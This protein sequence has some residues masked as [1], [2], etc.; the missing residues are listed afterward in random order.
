[1]LTQFINCY[2]VVYLVNQNEVN[3]LQKLQNRTVRILLSGNGY[4]P[5][6]DML[7]SL[8]W[9]SVQKLLEHNT[10]NFIIKIKRPLDVDIVIIL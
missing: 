9:L 8:K 10:L 2:S 4:I 3:R 5:I 1:M 7:L 6:R